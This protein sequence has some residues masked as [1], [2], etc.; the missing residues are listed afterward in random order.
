MS[1]E[2]EQG[3]ILSTSGALTIALAEDTETELLITATSTYAQTVFETITVK[4]TSIFK[5]I[6][7]GSTTTVTIDNTAFYVLAYDATKDQYLIFAK[8]PVASSIFDSM[9]YQWNTACE[10]YI[11]LQKWLS[12]QATLKD[13][14][15]QTTISTRSAPTS[16]SYI[17]ASCEIFLLSE[18]DL[19]GTADGT[20]T[21]NSSEYTY[22]NTQLTTNDTIR[23]FTVDCGEYSADNYWYWL[24]ST[25]S[26]ANGK[27]QVA[28]V[29]KEGELN[30]SPNYTIRGFA[31][32]PA[33]WV[34]GL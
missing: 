17:T 16:S 26:S 25:Y 19:Y 29:N 1:G 10:A 5:G 31:L 6:A 13:K 8:E 34:K 12:Q 4:P 23:G 15:Q 21:R 27:T 14:A 24:R 2:L 11:A 9:S 30:S 22:K 33:L 3:T 28:G 18:A 20:V 7:I 32:R